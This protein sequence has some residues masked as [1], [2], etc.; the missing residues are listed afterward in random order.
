MV[1]ESMKQG[2]TRFI[3]EKSSRY[4]HTHFKLA[5]G[6]TSSAGNLTIHL[7]RQDSGDFRFLIDF[8]IVPYILQRLLPTLQQLLHLHLPSSSSSPSPPLHR[9]ISVLPS[10]HYHIDFQNQKEKRELEKK[11][12]VIVIDEEEFCGEER[13]NRDGQMMN[14]SRSYPD[15]MKDFAAGL[16]F[17]SSSRSLDPLDLLQQPTNISPPPLLRFFKLCFSLDRLSR[18]A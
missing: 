7:L 14:R 4:T 18:R 15:F 12:Q 9:D 11:R 2:G 8:R 17:P 5:H 16:L 3:P 6:I 13:G 1:Q 10:L